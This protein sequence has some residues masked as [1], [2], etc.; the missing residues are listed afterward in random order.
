MLQVSRGR[1]D[2]VAAIIPGQ[3]HEVVFAAGFT[4]SG[5]GGVAAAGSAGF[6]DEPAAPSG[7]GTG[8][9]LLSVKSYI[10]TVESEIARGNVG[11]SHSPVEQFIA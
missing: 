8:V 4:G 6:E 10:M 1:Q 9:S 7:G 5:V 2:T 3:C 11:I